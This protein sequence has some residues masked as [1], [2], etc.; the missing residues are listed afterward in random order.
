MRNFYWN[1]GVR[2]CSVFQEIC[3]TILKNWHWSRNLRKKNIGATAC[4]AWARAET[5]KGLQKVLQI[6][7]M[8]GPTTLWTYP[9]SDEDILTKGLKRWRKCFLE[10][11]EKMYIRQKREGVILHDGNFDTTKNSLHTC[12]TLWGRMLF[13]SFFSSEKT[14]L[15][16]GKKWKKFR[17]IFS[18]HYLLKKIQSGKKFEIIFNL[19]RS[20]HKPRK[21]N[22]TMNPIFGLGH[23]IHELK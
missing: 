6:L 2:I 20:L 23:E 18:L 13:V 3:L 17:K 15:Q 4:R 1:N 11:N 22:E 8:T 10:K 5:F 9:V 21:I 12:L 14:Q 7:R 19:K 16:F